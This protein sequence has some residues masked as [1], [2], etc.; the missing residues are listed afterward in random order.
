MATV[1][2]CFNEV[3]GSGPGYVIRTSIRIGAQRKT[4]WGPSELLAYIEA[5]SPGVLA[6]PAWTEWG[7][8][9]DG[10]QTCAIVY[11]RVGASPGERNVPGYG[12]VHAYEAWHLRN[13]AHGKEDPRSNSFLL[14]GDDQ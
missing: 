10:S 9:A 11:G 12:I 7:H 1:R 4:D 6:D 2:D 5:E 13:E 3:I 8:L 14:D